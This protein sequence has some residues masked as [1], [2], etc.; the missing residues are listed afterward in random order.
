MQVNMMTINLQFIR[1]QN[2]SDIIPNDQSVDITSLNV[3]IT[4]QEVENAV[5]RSKCR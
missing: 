1:S 2:L 4:K 3:P 5:I